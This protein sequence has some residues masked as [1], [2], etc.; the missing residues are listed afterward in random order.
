MDPGPTEWFLAA[1]IR[2]VL[3]VAQLLPKWLV[4]LVVF[5]DSLRADGFGRDVGDLGLTRVLTTIVGATNLLSGA[6][7]LVRWERSPAC[8]GSAT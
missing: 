4:I 6:A 1:L 8:G 3:G 7:Y 2:A 5:R